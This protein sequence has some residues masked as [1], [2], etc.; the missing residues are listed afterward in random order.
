MLLKVFLRTNVPK[1]LN[2]KLHHDHPKDTPVL[3]KCAKKC[4]LEP[5]ALLNSKYLPEIAFLK[6][7]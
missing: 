1:N 5:G 7:G 6:S 4:L 3:L 2:K